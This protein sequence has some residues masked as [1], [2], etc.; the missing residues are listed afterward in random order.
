LKPKILHQ[1][2]PRPRAGQSGFDFRQGR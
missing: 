1:H 2:S